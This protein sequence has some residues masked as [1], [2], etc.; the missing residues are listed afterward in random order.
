MNMIDA[1]T[2]LTCTNRDCDCSLIV[3]SPC[4]HGDEYK[5]GCG[6]PLLPAG[7]VPEKGESAEIG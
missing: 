4:P 5:C 3:Q 6:H 2:E 7:A 1:G